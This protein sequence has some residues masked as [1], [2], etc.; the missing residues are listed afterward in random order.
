MMP[1]GSERPI[2]FMSRTLN[3]AERNYSQFYYYY[4]YSHLQGWQRSEQCRCSKSAAITNGIFYRAGG[5]STNAGE[6]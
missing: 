1:D 6:C 4:Y 2:G 5:K 3:Q